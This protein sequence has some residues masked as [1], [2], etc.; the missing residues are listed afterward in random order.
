MR[1]WWVVGFSLN[2]VRTNRHQLDSLITYG[3]YLGSY[4]APYRRE[5]LHSST[6]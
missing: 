3:A 1:G 4:E 2:V 6:V 5:M